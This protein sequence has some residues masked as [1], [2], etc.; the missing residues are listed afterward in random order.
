MPPS[1]DRECEGRNCPKVTLVRAAL[2]HVNAVR[3]ATRLHALLKKVMPS[4]GAGQN[5][6]SSPLAIEKGPIPL[7]GRPKIRQKEELP[8][9]Q[10]RPIPPHWGIYQDYFRIPTSVTGE[11]IAGRSATTIAALTQQ[12]K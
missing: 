3:E 6:K 2:G 9:I 4:E 10:A 12:R 5:E 8:T 11:E 1:G 7:N